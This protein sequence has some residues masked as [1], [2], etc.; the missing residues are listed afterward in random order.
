MA[1]VAVSS[2]MASCS[3]AIREATPSSDSF[4]R[5]RWKFLRVTG[6]CLLSLIQAL[7]FKAIA[8]CAWVF[9]Q[10]EANNHY[11]QLV[12]YHA[13]LG[14]N[15]FFFYLDYGDK[16][17]NFA[18]NTTGRPG[19]KEAGAAN[20]RGIY[21]DRFDRMFSGIAPS[22]CPVVPDKLKTLSVDSGICFGASIDFI[23]RLLREG[24][25]STSWFSTV[26]K[27]SSLYSEGGTPEAEIT[28]ILYKAQELSSLEAEKRQ[29]SDQ[30]RKELNKEIKTINLEYSRQNPSK[31]VS[32]VDNNILEREDQSEKREKALADIA[33]LEKQAINLLSDTYATLDLQRLQPLAALHELKLSMHQVIVDEGRKDTTSLKSFEELLKSCPIGVYLVSLSCSKDSL[34][35]H[36]VVY[37]KESDERGYVFDPNFA[38]IVLGNM[39]E[40]SKNFWKLVKEQYNKEGITSMKFYKAELRDVVA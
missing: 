33:D 12:Y 9:Q 35:A 16:V 39:K 37:V 3:V 2:Q 15:R 17:V 23:G 13:N 36:A 31:A 5:R 29:N 40:Q 21:G 27:V 11:S 18:A 24:Q 14:L 20:V 7:F 22:N 32:T 26:E 34:C 1:A 38:T 10:R 4:Y 19:R 25:C 8:A 6:G 28:Q 30:V